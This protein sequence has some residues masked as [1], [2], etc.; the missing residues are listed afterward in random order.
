MKKYLH[1]MDHV[2][3]IFLAFAHTLLILHYSY[4]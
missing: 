2:L 4:Q 1:Y 3:D